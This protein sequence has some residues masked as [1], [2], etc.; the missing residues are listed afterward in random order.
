MYSEHVSCGNCKCRRREAAIVE[1]KKPYRLGGLGER[2]K[3]PQ[4]GLGRSPKNRRNFEHFMPKWSAFWDVV[5][6]IYFNN[7]IEKIVGFLFMKR[8]WVFQTVPMTTPL[9]RSFKI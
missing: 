1:G 6:L 7:Q 9:K 3:L 2:R 8:G 4:Q 5:N